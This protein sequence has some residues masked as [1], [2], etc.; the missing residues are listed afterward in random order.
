MH[1]LQHYI[2]AV[3][4]TIRQLALLYPKQFDLIEPALNL[5]VRRDVPGSKR[6]G[7]RRT[8]PHQFC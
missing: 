7:V 6:S 3:T 4:A 1:P 5:P 2:G 8:L